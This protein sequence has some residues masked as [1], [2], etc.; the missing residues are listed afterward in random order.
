MILKYKTTFVPAAQDRIGVSFSA[1]FILKSNEPR[2]RQLKIITN[3]F[4]DII[5]I[6]GVGYASA[7]QGVYIRARNGA[8]ASI[9]FTGG[10]STLHKRSHQL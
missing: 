8:T 5:T 1:Q 7:P 9:G 3:G 6:D 4:A 10:D 2:V